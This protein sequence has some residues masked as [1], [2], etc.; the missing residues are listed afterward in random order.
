MDRQNAARVCGTDAWTWRWGRSA[1]VGA[2]LLP[3]VTPAPAGRAHLPQAPHAAGAP[4]DGRTDEPGALRAASTR[5]SCSEQDRASF[6][7]FTGR[8]IYFPLNYLLISF[9]RFSRAPLGLLTSASSVGDA[10]PISC[11]RRPPTVT[12]SQ[13]FAGHSQPLPPIT[14]S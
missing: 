8:L 13:G 7:T 4:T 9:A 12:P 3:A 6:H 5:V 1:G 11:G 10:S 14:S 2:A